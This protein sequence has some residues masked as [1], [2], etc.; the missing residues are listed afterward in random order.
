VNYVEEDGGWRQLLVD[1]HIC[2]FHVKQGTSLREILENGDRLRCCRR[3]IV[4]KVSEQ[5]ACLKCV[6]SD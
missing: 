5:V 3:L 6:E 1:L 4:I 2:C